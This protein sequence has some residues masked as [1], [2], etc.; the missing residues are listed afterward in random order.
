MMFRK[1]PRTRLRSIAGAALM[2]AGLLA[3]APAAQAS[4]LQGGFFTASVTSDGH[5]KGTM[6]YLE[7]RACASGVGS[8][9]SQD[10][11][12][13]SPNGEVVQ[14][15]TITGAAT[16]CRASE[17]V[18]ELPFDFPLATTFANGTPDGD[19]TISWR[20]GNRVAGIANYPNSNS[21]YVALSAQ[22]HKVTGQTTSAPILGSSAATGISVVRQDPQNLNASDPDGGTLSYQTALKTPPGGS[23]ALT[24]PDSP[25]TDIVAIDGNG[26]LSIPNATSFTPGAFYVYKLRVTDSQGDFADRDVLMTVAP[27]GQAPP[28]INGLESEYT[29]KPGET[30]TITFSADDTSTSPNSVTLSPAGLP[31]WAT[32][33]QT[34]GNPATATLTLSPPAN[35]GATTTG[36]NVDATTVAQPP[37]TSTRTLRV[38]VQPDTPAPSTTTPAPTTS[39]PAATTP[40]TAPAVTPI[41][42]TVPACE[43]RYEFG[44]VKLDSST[45]FTIEN[46]LD[47]KPA[48]WVSTGTVKVN[49]LPV[50]PAKAGARFVVTLPTTA[51]PRARVTDDNA[52]I[53]LTAFNVYSGKVDWLLPT[54]TAAD[55]K[56][57]GAGSTKVADDDGIRTLQTAP[58]AGAA[59]LMGLKLRGQIAIKVGKTDAGQ[60]F[61]TLP[62]T[63]EM[64]S[65]FR[66]GPDVSAGG[67]TANASLRI[68]DAGTHFD[69]LRLI[70]R[71]VWMGKLRVEE[72][73][74][75]YIPA[76][77]QSGEPCE[78]PEL[79]GKPYVTCNSDSNA[80]RWDGNAVIILPTK[81]ETK[82]AAF[83]GV[84][85]GS[86]SKLGGFVDNLGNK[87]P[88]ATGVYLNR[89]GIGLCLNP[90]PFKLRG[91]V[92]VSVFPTAKEELLGINGHILYTDAFN[93]HPWS[94]EVGGSVEVFDKLIGQGSLTI[95]PTGALDFD[96]DAG[97]SLLGV[98]SVNGHLEGW[99]ETSTK[100]FNI[101]G[102]GR[103][104]LTAICARADAIASS[105]GMGGCA[106]I[107]TIVYYY[108]VRAA[109]WKWY[110][111]WRINWIRGEIPLRSGFG[112]RWHASSVNMLGASCDF[113]PYRAQ[114]TAGLSAKGDQTL[115]IAKGTP[116]IALQLKGANG[117]APT[118]T[119]HGPKGEEL[120]VPADQ[121]AKKLANGSMIIKNASDG[122]TSVLLV[123]PSA[124]KWT[125]ATPSG[126]PRITQVLTSAYEP[127]ATVQ[128]NVHALRG[129]VERISS[130]YTLPA[131]ATLSYVEKGDGVQRTLVGRVNGKTCPGA[132]ASPDGRVVKCHTVDFRPSTGPGG[133]RSI[134]AVVERD[135]LPLSQKTVATFVAP[136]QHLPATPTRLR[137]VRFARWV[138][139]AWDE[140]ASADRYSVAVTTSTGARYG[141]LLPAGCKSI[142]LPIA[143]GTAVKVSV[144]GVRDDLA[145]G[146]RN[147]GALKATEKRSGATPRL[148]RK[149]WVKRTACR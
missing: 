132:K 17:G 25:D 139:A 116:A 145:V 40:A 54:G 9:M 87:V 141:R 95:R 2:C 147:R 102:S 14:S 103:A 5:L 96:V 13:K 10:V 3:A 30:K 81:T 60:Y 97:M 121:P 45:C 74:L 85:N 140:D 80:N 16:V 77:G 98:V 148:P 111:P 19:Y 88:V 57:V 118:V 47:G 136:K 48:R 122:S 115:R 46:G 79:D 105:T 93:G 99:L 8:L 11:D 133:R 89:V 143:N 117:Q 123:Q 76:G 20:S 106:T 131:G 94:L 107:A 142:A 128:A 39:T 42:P 43:K 35:L 58:V 134:I 127:P 37:L 114:R 49:G 28:N 84:S 130:A 65:T 69:G 55:L 126:S 24:D 112:Y 149:Q 15:Q 71:Q 75:S 6:T 72:A 41:V 26:V 31:S 32:L 64:P 73:C 86:I 59:T 12:L 120:A 29:V 113:G 67:V 129:G 38:K 22:V 137:M 109:D 110:A 62:L 56:V 100:K 18:Y 51:Q 23:N 36:I 21:A 135:G 33:T 52:N 50:T 90:P 124:G 125:I 144:A 83:G 119:L 82:L 138:V 108:P 101:E 34:T 53:N 44:T 7:R 66:S 92:G 104:C 91:D 61:T 63:I 4:H 78:A 70:A 1:A 27:A 146:A 68:D